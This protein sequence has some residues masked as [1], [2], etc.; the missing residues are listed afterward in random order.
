[1]NSQIFISVL[2]FICLAI[3]FG[4]C[5][6][7]ED[8]ILSLEIQNIIPDTLMDQIN[9]L[10]MPIYKGTTPPNIEEI[11][12][13][14]PFVLVKSN[15]ETDSPGFLYTDFNVKFFNQ[16]SSENSINV[17]F[18]N[19]PEK[20]NDLAGYVSGKNNNFSVFLKQTTSSGDTQAELVQII[21]GTRNN[22]GINNF[23]YAVF[24]LNN[25]GN[26]KG[27]W[28]ENGQGRIIYDSDGT[29]PVVETLYS[30]AHNEGLILK[31][32]AAN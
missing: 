20:G 6:K 1:M 22:S 2:V 27:Y 21:S 26:K 10:G 30:Y 11:F 31:S 8:D 3:S 25:F 28:I 14:S 18:V 29:S 19:G 7:D 24:M 32:C 17:S 4:S 23:Y 9:A 12:Q 13:A 16:D 15:I 5:K